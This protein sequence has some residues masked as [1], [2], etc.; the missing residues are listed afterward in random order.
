[1]KKNRFY[2]S[3]SSVTTIVPSRISRRYLQ[4]PLGLVPF[5]LIEFFVDIIVDSHAV[6]RSNTKR[7]LLPF[8][9]FSPMVTFYKTIVNIS[10]RILTLIPS[11][12]LIQLL[13]FI[14]TPL[15]LCVWVYIVLCNFITLQVY[16]YIYKNLF[17][18]TLVSLYSF[19]S[20]FLL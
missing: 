15:C 16:V 10:T 7:S 4:T 11:T 12:N 17:T 20:D 1:M 6:I 18:I 5:F 13:S 2:H 9:Q 8:I 3:L 19:I 14:C